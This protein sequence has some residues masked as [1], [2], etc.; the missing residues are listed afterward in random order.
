MLRSLIT[1]NKLANLARRIFTRAVSGVKKIAISTLLFLLAGLVILLGFYFQSQPDWMVK[2]SIQAYNKA[3]DA[4]HLPPGSLPA[5]DERPAEWPLDRARA[6]WE[7][8]A[9]DSQDTRLRAL[10]LYNMG[11]M[12]AREAYASN[13]GHALLDAP[14]VD[15]TEAVLMLAESVRLDP[16]NEDAKYNLEV[17]DQVLSIQGVEQGAPGPG[18]SQG[19]ADKGY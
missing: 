17:L 19:A 14:R 10:T 5:S 15:M 3:V 8:A 7:M 16:R 9:S 2:P 18:Y 1:V 12:V 4:Y 6:Y 11:T 13:L